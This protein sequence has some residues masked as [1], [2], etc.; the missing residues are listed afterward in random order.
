LQNY[1]HKPKI[2]ENKDS[3]KD[4]DDVINNDGTPK[5][6]TMRTLTGLDCYS[7]PET[8]QGGEYT[9]AIDLWGIGILLY[10]IITG[11]PPFIHHDETKLK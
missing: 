9:E 10:Y 1:T 2:N 3:L 7:A 6:I 8:R 4:L 5:R 11:H